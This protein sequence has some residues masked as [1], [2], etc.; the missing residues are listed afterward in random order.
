MG[1]KKEVLEEAP[2]QEEEPPPPEIAIRVVREGGAVFEGESKLV[3][4]KVIKHGSGVLL[5]VGQPKDG[6]EPVVI[7]RYEGQFFED[8]MQ[9]NGVMH[10]VDGS[11]YEGEFAADRID[12]LGVFRWP[13]GQ[14]TYEGMWKDGKMHG[15]GKMVESSGDLHTGVFYQNWM[16][17]HKGKWRNFLKAEHE[18]EKRGMMHLGARL[19]P[20]ALLPVSVASGPNE[21]LDSLMGSYQANQIPFVISSDTDAALTALHEATGEEPLPV[22]MKYAAKMKARLHDWKGLFRKSITAALEEARPLAI[23]FDAYDPS[24]PLPAEWSV[25]EFWGEAGGLPCELFDPNKFHG[26]GLSEQ[27]GNA[28]A[29]REGENKA[30][31]TAAEEPT[32][33][34]EPQEASGE[35]APPPPSAE[36]FPVCHR[37]QFVVIGVHDVSPA[38]LADGGAL[39]GSV[40]LRFGMHVPLHR[41]SLV[42]L[43]ML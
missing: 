10:F 39:R 3:D 9:G 2:P 32:E 1:P 19:T 37:L 7:S 30:D 43:T 25:K 31:E 28:V 14:S 12:G 15:H 22:H 42:A 11:R 23:V 6:Q 16:K 18:A 21:L 4:G 41:C 20:D 27:F 34:K 5:Q 17:D 26:R 29:D 13:N 8:T 35:E 24:E 40:A 38:S 36:G 33:A